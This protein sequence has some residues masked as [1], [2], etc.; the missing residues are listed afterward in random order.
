MAIALVI[1]AGKVLTIAWNLSGLFRRGKGS[2]ITEA[3]ASVVTPLLRCWVVL[4][5]PSPAIVHLGT[6]LFV[7][8]SQVSKLKKCT[9]GGFLV[10]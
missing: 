5:H 9:S 4:K 1:T 3:D 10:S 6:P 2:G 8:L 7:E